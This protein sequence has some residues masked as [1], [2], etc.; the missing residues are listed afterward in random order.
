M[1]RSKQRGG[2][3]L[4][5]MFTIAIISCSLFL[6]PWFA[7]GFVLLIPLTVEVSRSRSQPAGRFGRQTREQVIQPPVPL[8]SSIVLHLKTP[9]NESFQELVVDDADQRPE[10]INQ[11]AIA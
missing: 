2:G 9:T 1:K 6:S 7:A 3:S 10:E 11:R 5:L 8:S 4:D